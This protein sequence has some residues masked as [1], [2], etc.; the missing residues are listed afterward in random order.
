MRKG[1]KGGF[2][3]GIEM[4]KGKTRSTEHGENIKR[5]GPSISFLVKLRDMEGYDR[6][7]MLLGRALDKN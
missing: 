5:K 7:L 2:I 4:K 6:S 1:E 3:W